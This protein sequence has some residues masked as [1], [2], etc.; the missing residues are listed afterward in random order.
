MIA[1]FQ[2]SSLG[3]KGN[4]NPGIILGELS[5]ITDKID[6]LAAQ[7]GLPR[8]AKWITSLRSVNQSLLYSGSKHLFAAQNGYFFLFSL[9]QNFILDSLKR[10]KHPAY[11]KML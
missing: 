8:C 11:G 4:I 9:P 3:M 1:Y 6:Y 5:K 7:N 2:I 10:K